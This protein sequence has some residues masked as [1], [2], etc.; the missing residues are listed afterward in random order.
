MEEDRKIDY[1][2]MKK[3]ESMDD[4]VQM[5]YLELV[6]TAAILLLVHFFLGIHRVVDLLVGGRNIH[7]RVGN[8]E[9]ARLHGETTVFDRHDGEVFDTRQVSDTKGVPQDNVLLLNVLDTLVGPDFNS[10]ITARLVTVET[11]SKH[12]VLIIGSDPQSLLGETS[13]FGNK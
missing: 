8:E 10:V 11:T 3:S 5:G 6:G 2:F 1:D 9:V 13:A 7:T 12:L 4:F